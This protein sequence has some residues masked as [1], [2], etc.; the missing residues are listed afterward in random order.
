MEII[1]RDGFALFLFISATSIEG[2][3]SFHPPCNLRCP[4]V[5]FL[6]MFLQIDMMRRKLNDLSYDS[7]I[8]TNM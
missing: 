8:Q 2:W 6:A 1:N 4:G 3:A 5:M 7:H